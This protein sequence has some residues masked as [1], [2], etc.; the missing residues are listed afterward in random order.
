[1]RIEILALAVK[2]MSRK[3]EDNLLRCLIEESRRKSSKEP[4]EITEEEIRRTSI[5]KT[6]EMNS[7]LT[8]RKISHISDKQENDTRRKSSANPCAAEERK[9]SGGLNI[10]RKSYECI[11]ENGENVRLAEAEKAIHKLIAPHGIGKLQT[12]IDRRPRGIKVVPCKK[13]HPFGCETK[14]THQR[15]W[16]PLLNGPPLMDN[17]W[18]GNT[19]VPTY[20]TTHRDTYQAEKC[21]RN[22]CV[23]T[24]AVVHL[25]YG[26][27]DALE[28]CY[29]T[30]YRD[31]FRHP[32]SYH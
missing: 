15:R 29:L 32:D 13:E 27:L 10:K 7:E 22:K 4:D 6:E 31:M 9:D 5:K 20:T 23:H 18:M 19:I 2:L 17:G 30:S 12:W 25:G 26:Y 16:S 11:D 3:S 14:D 28:K 8:E 1:M 24:P 21:P